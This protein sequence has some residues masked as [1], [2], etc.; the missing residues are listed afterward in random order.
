[1]HDD[2]RQPG[3]GPSAEQIVQRPF[4]VVR[5]GLAEGEV[6]SWLGQIAGEVDRLRR[7]VADAEARAAQVAPPTRLSEGE[8]LAALG[9]ETARVLQSA[10]EA[11]ADIRRKAED[12]AAALLRE[13]QDDATEIRDDAGGLLERRTTEAEA[14]AARILEEAEQQAAEHRVDADAYAVAARDDADAYAEVV[15]RR[16]EEEAHAAVEAAKAQGRELVTEAQAVRER[17]LGD[18]ARRRAIAQ[19]RV[20]EL[21]DGSRR[22]LDA[23]AVARRNLEQAED[24]VAAADAAELMAAGA[25][26]RPPIE[27]PAFV[28]GPHPVVVADAGAAVDAVDAAGGT[29]DADPVLVVADADLDA[30]PVEVPAHD[31]ADHAGGAAHDHAEVD[32]ADVLLSVGAVPG[33]DVDLDDEPE[34]EA[35]ADVEVD[36]ADVLLAAGP[37]P[38]PA[39][40]LGVAADVDLDDEPQ[41]EADGDAATDDGDDDLDAGARPDVPVAH[42]HG[43]DD[44]GLDLDLRDGGDRSA[45]SGDAIEALFARLRA[46]RRD[47]VDAARAVL[48]DGPVA[49]LDDADRPRAEAPTA[50]SAPLGQSA[51]HH[52]DRSDHEVHSVATLPRDPAIAARDALVE[53][54]V[55]HLVRQVKRALQDDQ[56]VLLE[57]IRR[58]TSRSG[59][60]VAGIDELLPEHEAQLL[61]LAAVA[62][63]VLTDVWL[64]VG[65]AGVDPTAVPHDVREAT[66]TELTQRF[67]REVLIPLR[68]RLEA[69]VLEAAD[70]ATPAAELA[71]RVSNHYREWKVQRAEPAVVELVA[72]T[73]ARAV[74]DA[75]P[76][77]VVLRWVADSDGPCADAEDNALEPTVRGCPFPTGHAVPPAH[78]GCRCFLVVDGVDVEPPVPRTAD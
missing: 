37:L 9:E 61:A 32:P 33:P 47:D 30:E 39:D 72:A 55:G 8:L 56:N 19:Q 73:A 29:V 45:D 21:Q 44:G 36:P 68:D 62:Q 59:A 38:E 31:G 2:D 65:F 58:G 24:A 1:M 28:T 48:G 74:L 4:T 17:I 5:K 43:P 20:E 12:R 67:A 7:Q 10:Q 78:P 64:A 60:V 35:G 50:P 75:A 77:D 27:P 34:A 66:L 42:G 57:A 11:A 3:A 18:L 41:A 69:A 15:R 70:N 49:V 63:P 51:V 76:A 71:D 54:I 52:V 6:R 26:P 53:P 46:T 14:A 40:D 13:A 25:L 22:L 23:L 16:S